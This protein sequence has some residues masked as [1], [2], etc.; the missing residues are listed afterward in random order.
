MSNPTKIMIIRHAEKP[1]QSGFPHAVTMEGE[2]DPDLLI[3]KGWH[4][5]G[6]L[7]CF[8]APQYGN[9]QNSQLA[10]PQFLYASASGKH[11][12]KS[13]RPM[14]TIMP[15]SSKLGLKVNRKYFIGEH[16]SLLQSV[17]KCE[18][19]VLISWEHHDIPLIANH[20]LGDSE[21]V[22]QKWP[23]DRFDIVW[24]FEWD[25]TLAAYTFSQ[26]PQNLLAGDLETVIT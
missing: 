5:A 16:K 25:P 6:A 21:T 10:K 1:E 2:K 22:P 12:K 8:F 17:L 9:L 19:V 13:R 24:V 15:L 18:G 3:V 11:H 20:I 7:V 23:G 4:R 26:V 14:A